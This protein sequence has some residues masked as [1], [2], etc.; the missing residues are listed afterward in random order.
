MVREGPP[1]NTL[2][3][4]QEKSKAHITDYFTEHLV[5]GGGTRFH[6]MWPGASSHYFRRK[7]LLV[8]SSKRNISNPNCSYFTA[9]RN[10]A[11]WDLRC[12]E[13][14]ALTVLITA[15]L[16]ELGTTSDTSS[17]GWRPYLEASVD[18]SRF[19]TRPAFI[20]PSCPT[21]QTH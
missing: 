10:V 14:H 13:Q 7:L 6:L 5:N 11:V 18:R 1:P 15:K 12:W 21:T 4:P 20:E 19:E 2:E 9:V 16:S 17:R 3:R 8:E